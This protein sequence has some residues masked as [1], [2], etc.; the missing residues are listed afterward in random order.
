MLRI[1]PN[2]DGSHSIRLSSYDIPAQFIEVAADVPLAPVVEEL[3]RR[4]NIPPADV[5]YADPI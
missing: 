4:Y 5:T 3:R 1:F 2:F